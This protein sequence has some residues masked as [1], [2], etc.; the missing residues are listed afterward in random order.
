MISLGQDA[1]VGRLIA[2]ELQTG[3]K[4]L[5][6]DRLNTATIG[7]V[8]SVFYLKY[9]RLHEISQVTTADGLSLVVIHTTAPHGLSDN[10]TVHIGN[11]VVQPGF[12]VGGT[13]TAD[14]L[15]GTHVVTD[16]NSATSFTIDCGVEATALDTAVFTPHLRVDRYKYI[17][18]SDLSTTWAESTTLPIA[19]HSNTIEP[20]FS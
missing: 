9:S 12:I 15:L 18:M 6:T 16:I 2:T 5:G 7:H 19:S 11:G 8:G 1:R 13:I 20:F 3:T 4:V 10:E 17:E 14:D